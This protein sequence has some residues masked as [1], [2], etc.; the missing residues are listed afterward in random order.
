MFLKI[1]T[2]FF[3]RL[4]DDVIKKIYHRPGSIALIKSEG[5]VGACLCGEY[6]I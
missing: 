1:F 2:F 4:A 6:H 3:F 5:E